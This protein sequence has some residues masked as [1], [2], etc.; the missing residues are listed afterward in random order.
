M[1]EK[2]HDAFALVQKLKLEAQGH[3]QEARTANS[4]IAEIYQHV[5]EHSG[6]P[7]NWNGA[8]PVADELRRLREFV[9]WVDSWVSRP[10]GSYS[11]HAIDG[12][13]GM[14]RDKIEAL[15]R[16]RAQQGEA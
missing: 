16:P 12:L 10:V 13:F 2:T 15:R 11:I 1:T 14:T 5:T 6:E 3:A 9:G 7:G 8:Q 4:T